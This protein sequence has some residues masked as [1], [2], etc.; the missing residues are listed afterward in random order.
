MSPSAVA[1]DVNQP[2]RLAAQLNSFGT[3]DAPPY[4]FMEREMY[5]YR[6]V[7]PWP[8]AYNGSLSGS[9]VVVY[10]IIAILP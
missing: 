4:L 9:L 8:M 5:I 6:I 10:V 7:G 2:V 1:A 3:P